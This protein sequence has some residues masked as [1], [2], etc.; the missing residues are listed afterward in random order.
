MNKQVRIAMIMLAGL[1]SGLVGPA[2]IQMSN[3]VAGCDLVAGCGVSDGIGG[4]MLG[5]QP[6][7]DMTVSDVAT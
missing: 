2:V 5:D 4:R 7:G 1:V 3:Q 6:L